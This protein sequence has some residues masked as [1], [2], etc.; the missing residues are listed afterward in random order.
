MLEV[1]QNLGVS[2]EYRMIVRRADGSVKFDSGVQ[3]N[4]VLDNALRHY[5]GLTVRNSAGVEYPLSTSSGFSVMQNCVVGTGNTPPQNTDIALQNFVAVN[6]SL[7]AVTSSGGSTDYGREEPSSDKH[8]GFVKLWTIQKYVFTGIENK[9]ISEVGLVARFV[10]SESLG[11]ATYQNAYALMTRALVKDTSGTPLAITVLAGEVLEVMYQVNVY[12][13]IS[14][15]TGSFTLASKVGGQTTNATFDYAL[16]LANVDNPY[17]DLVLQTLG[18]QA[19][20][21]I[22]SYGVKETDA[23]LSASYDLNDASWQ[24]LTH[25]NTSVISSKTTG[26]KS[27]QYIYPNKT[28]PGNYIP[29]IVNKDFNTKTISVKTYC[30][31]YTHVY[32]NGIRAYSFA[33][34]SASSRELMR[35]FVW[36][37]NRANGQGIKKTDRQ[38]WETTFSITIDRWV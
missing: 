24:T 13:D 15:K 17:G 7:A 22:N 8:P 34:I 2:G 10:N 4:L 14:R 38:A 12:V 26:A 25:T 18:N 3:Q 28:S 16:Q 20:G 30:G 27:S 11:G 32:T 6:S 36:V 5:L 33:I 31:I 21:G 23:E 1:K 19:G 9:N 35:A 29:E 37:K